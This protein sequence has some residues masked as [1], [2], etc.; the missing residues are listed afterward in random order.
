[1][2]R[3]VSDGPRGTTQDDSKKWPSATLN[4]IGNKSQRFHSEVPHRRGTNSVQ[5][6]IWMPAVL[7]L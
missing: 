1:M 5:A 3:V 7:A 4:I 6:G 2:R